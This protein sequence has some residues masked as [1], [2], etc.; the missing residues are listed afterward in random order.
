MCSSDLTD[1]MFSVKNP[2]HFSTPDITG[3]DNGWWWFPVQ[4]ST[5]SE[6][7]YI[8]I[9]LLAILGAL[10]ITYSYSFLLVV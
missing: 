2:S 10:S 5:M 9:A 1:E 7:E 8:L 6:I 3:R 4:A